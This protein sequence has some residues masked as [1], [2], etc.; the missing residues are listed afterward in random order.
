MPVSMQI[1]NSFVMLAVVRFEQT[2]LIIAEVEGSR[3]CVIADSFRREVIAIHRGIGIL[4]MIRPCHE[5]P[6]IWRMMSKQKW[7]QLRD[8]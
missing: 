6:W 4:S 7:R 8:A 2:R 3:H 5:S 1:V